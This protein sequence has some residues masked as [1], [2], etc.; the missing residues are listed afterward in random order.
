MIKQGRAEARNEKA[1][2]ERC[3]EGAKQGKELKQGMS[4]Q[5]RDKARNEKQRKGRSKE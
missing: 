1:R 4:K 5:G 2:K 3:M